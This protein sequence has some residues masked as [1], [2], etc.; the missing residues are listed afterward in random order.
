MWFD[1]CHYPAMDEFVDEG[2]GTS[3]VNKP[4][5]GVGIIL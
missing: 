5:L 4:Y 2:L 1:V 3:V